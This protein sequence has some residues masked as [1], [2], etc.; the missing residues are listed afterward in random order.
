MML[1]LPAYFLLNPQFKTLGEARGLSDVVQNFLVMTTGI[2]S[3]GGAAA[4]LLGVR[5]D[6]PQ[7][8]DLP[9]HRRDAFGFCR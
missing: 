6:R 9:D 2:A 1:L 4:V 7:K 8:R 3:A 5:P